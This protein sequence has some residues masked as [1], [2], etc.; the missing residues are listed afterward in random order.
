MDRFQG[1]IAERPGL[2]TPLTDSARFTVT[3]LDVGS[4]AVRPGLMAEIEQERQMLLLAA[5]LVLGHVR[6]GGIPIGAAHEL[7]LENAIRIAE[8][9]R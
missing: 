7:A 1:K 2:K 4:E 8:L 3:K 5:K 9:P 6:A